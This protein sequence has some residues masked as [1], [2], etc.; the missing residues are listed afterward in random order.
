MKSP[1]LDFLNFKN[2][3]NDK[4]DQIKTF[5]AQIKRKEERQKDREKVCC[6]GIGTNGTLDRYVRIEGTNRDRLGKS[7]GDKTP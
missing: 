1:I 7:I 4:S 5:P 3:Q 6:F 2:S